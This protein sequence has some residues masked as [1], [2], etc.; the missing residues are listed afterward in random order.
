M[1][2]PDER[3]VTMATVTAHRQR[4]FLLSLLTLLTLLGAIFTSPVDVSASTHPAAETRVRA[5]DT[6]TAVLVGRVDAASSTTVGVS[7]VRLRQLVS[8]T[9]VATGGASDLVG[10][11]GS[12]P[13][14]RPSGMQSHHGVNSVWADANIPGHHA[15]EAP[16][17]LMPKAAHN[18]TFG[19]F[20]RWRSEMAGRQGVP[21]K[22]IDWGAVP[23]GSIW[24]LAEDQFAA[25]GTAASTIEDYFG[26]W[27]QYVD[28]L[29]GGS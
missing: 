19:V 6:P 27:N 8:A 5:F 18:A 17:V 28:G 1:S 26:Q 7:S 9:G 23:P 21:I 2:V 29:G 25:A 14:P 11:H 20:N 4:G 12:M 3:I 15:K 10:R 24:R 16:A 22:D 13:R